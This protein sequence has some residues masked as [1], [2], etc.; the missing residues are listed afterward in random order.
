[1]EEVCPL[2]REF[3]PGVNKYTSFSHLR[4][5]SFAPMK[6][7]TS[8]I[9]LFCL[10]GIAQ[11]PAMIEA[12]LQSYAQYAIDE[13]IRTGIPA[14]ITLAQGIHESGAGLGDLATRSNNHFGIKC[15]T[16]WNG[17]KVFHD[18]D[19]RGECFRAYACVADSYRDHS[20]FIRTGK[21]YSFL[22]DFSPE[23]YISW[24]NGLKQA[25]YAT[26]PRYSQILI[27]T[28][29][30]HR[31]GEFTAMAIARAAGEKPQ[32]NQTI[33]LAASKTEAP[34]QE[35]QKTVAKNQR[36]QLETG[37]LTSQEVN[38]KVAKGDATKTETSPVPQGFFKINGCKA[39]FAVSG[40][41]LKTL[42]R[43]QGLSYTDLLS[44]NDM[45]PVDKLAGSQIIF[46]EPKKKKGNNKVHEVQKGESAWLISQQEGMILAKL[47]EY[48]HLTASAILKPGQQLYLKRRAPR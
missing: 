9:T 37:F 41:T 11:K 44:Y 3:P 16:G 25:G 2:T 33:W 12:Y 19:E 42:A 27:K 38:E 43:Q 21:R 8:I 10:Q 30:E 28:I 18:D 22:F 24:A 13:Q 32:A 45:K 7:L 39:I 48:N 4:R 20:D 31:L 6:I 40:T 47:L 36:P 35:T 15:K 1:M 23:D 46:L 34:A 14:A 29:E 17:D 5:F 26:N